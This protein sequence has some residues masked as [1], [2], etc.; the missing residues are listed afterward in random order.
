MNDIA[1]LGTF[2]SV[3]HFKRFLDESERGKYLFSR[4]WNLGNDRENIL[5]KMMKDKNSLQK[6]LGSDTVLTWIVDNQAW[7]SW[8]LF[9]AR[10]VFAS[11]KRHKKFLITV[12]CS[13]L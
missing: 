9:F 5:K 11:K 8:R 10:K 3:K 1:K 7:A 6:Q 2:L 13:C 4:N 12:Y